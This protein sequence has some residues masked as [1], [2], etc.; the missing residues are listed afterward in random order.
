MAPH[1]FTEVPPDRDTLN[2]KT[3]LVIDDDELVLRFLGRVLR[4]AGYSVRHAR[5]GREA[6]K[7][8]TAAPPPDLV[9]TDLMM[10][11]MDGI[12]TIQ[13]LK[14]ALPSLPIIAISGDG[15]L[16]PELGLRFATALGARRVLAKPFGCETLL[17]AVQS[18]LDRKTCDAVPAASNSPSRG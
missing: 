4:E 10:P 7:H 2:M 13:K 18:V 14:Q 3:I 17:Q 11:E 1:R 9:I 15:Q 16:E 8:F 5:N 12:E 6:T